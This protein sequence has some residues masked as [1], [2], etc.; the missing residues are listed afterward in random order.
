MLPIAAV[1]PHLEVDHNAIWDEVRRLKTETGEIKSNI[2]DLNGKLDTQFERLAG[3][4]DTLG[5]VLMERHEMQKQIVKDVNILYERQR[6]TETHLSSLDYT[7]LER[8]I[9]GVEQKQSSHGERLAQVG[10]CAAIAGILLAGGV[11]WF[12]GK[13]DP[14]KDETSSDLAAVIALDFR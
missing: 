11:A 5:A 7:A 8:R 6:Q 3:R 12:F 9:E 14:Q 10:I 4:L 2:R 13:T 1:P